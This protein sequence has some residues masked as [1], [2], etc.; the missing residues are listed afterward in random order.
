MRYVRQEQEE[1]MT[2]LMNLFGFSLIH[3]KGFFDKREHAPCC[4]GIIKNRLQRKLFG[5]LTTLVPLKVMKILGR[6]IF[7]G[8]VE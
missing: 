4:S 7:D 6:Y 5:T 1:N 3:I 8:D 2:K